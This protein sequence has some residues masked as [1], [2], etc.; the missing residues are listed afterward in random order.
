MAL[1]IIVQ[2][3][4]F[5]ILPWNTPA[6]GRV[7]FWYQQPCQNSNNANL[8]RHWLLNFALL[9]QQLPALKAIP[10]LPFG[11]ALYSCAQTGSLLSIRGILRRPLLII[12]KSNI[13]DRVFLLC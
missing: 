4:T 5:D 8:F 2:Q 13:Q 3:K 12:Q 7:P 1:R 6:I 10:V 11:T 9:F